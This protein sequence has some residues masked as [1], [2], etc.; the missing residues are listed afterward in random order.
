VSF[1][2]IVYQGYMRLPWRRTVLTFPPISTITDL[3]R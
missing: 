3:F 2:H 1:R